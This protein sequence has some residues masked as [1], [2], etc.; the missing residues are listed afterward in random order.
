MID[1]KQTVSLNT[2][3][4]QEFIEIDVPKDGDILDLDFNGRYLIQCKYKKSNFK[5]TGNGMD[6]G[7]NALSSGFYKSCIIE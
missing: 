6:G 2:G 4:E 1:R 5:P 7:G 3:S